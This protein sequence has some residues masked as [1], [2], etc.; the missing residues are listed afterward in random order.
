MLGASLA[1]TAGVLATATNY[2]TYVTVA[3]TSTLGYG[4]S[5]IE[6]PGGT[7]TANFGAGSYQ[8]Q[9]LNSSGVPVKSNVW[10]VT[11]SARTAHTFEASFDKASYS[12]GDI[13]TMTITAKDSGGR[14]LP[15]SHPLIGLAIV[16][17]SGLTVA[18]TAC[19]A[20]STFTNGVKTCTFGVGNTAGSYAWSVG[21][22]NASSQNPVLGSVKVVDGAVSNAEVLKSIVAL[23][24]SINKQI[25]ALQ[26][27]ILKR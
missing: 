7:A 2:A 24:A 4:A 22:T 23:I 12:P 3:Q 17:G 25:A 18:G 19:D 8:I 13:A 20:T 1:T 14:L 10:D 9:V 16:T 5:S 21:L 15:S 27:L 26:K 6:H 11:V